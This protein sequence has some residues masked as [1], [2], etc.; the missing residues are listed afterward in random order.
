[1]EAA[2]GDDN[3]LSGLSVAAQPQSGWP[4]AIRPSAAALLR[5]TTMH[6]ETASALEELCLL[7]GELLVGEDSLRVQVAEL[8]QILVNVCFGGC[9]FCFDVL[10]RLLRGRCR[11]LLATVHPA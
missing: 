5:E 1:M 6:V 2:E 11:G 10:S 8:L 3:R 4:G 9:R 7:G